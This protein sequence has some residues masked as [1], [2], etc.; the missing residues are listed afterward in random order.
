MYTIKEEI[1]IILSLISFGIYLFASLDIVEI[2]VSKINNKIIKI[3]CDIIFLF[4]Q[5]YIIF[6]FS[7]NLMEGYI[8]IYFILFIYI[9]YLIYDKLCK[10]KFQHLILHLLS[11]I[12]KIMIL[13]KKII[14]PLLYSK[15]VKMFFKREVKIIKKTFNFRKKEKNN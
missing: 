12:K 8:P 2:I 14:K 15:E 11:L 13:I 5:I 10:R 6:I 7:Y 1:Y 9:G 3:I 4:I